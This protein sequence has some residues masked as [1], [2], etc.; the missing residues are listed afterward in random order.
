[1][2]VI[3]DNS[4]LSALAEAELLDL[5]P[6][7][8]GTITIPETVQR[9]SVHPN[10]PQLLKQSLASPP[11][12][13]RV[14]PDPDRF[15]PETAGLDGG[16]AAAI[17]IAWLHRDSSTLLIDEK[18]GRRVAELLGL[19]KIGTLAI[20]GK[21]ATRNWIVFDDVLLRLEEIGFHV[22]ESVIDEIRRRISTQDSI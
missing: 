18:K 9:E 16:E 1:M 12:W 11:E 20:I 17:T 10:A 15:L 4:V 3:S 13:L 6:R 8:F 7:L 2:I 19:R 21:A 22:S 14:V 5:L